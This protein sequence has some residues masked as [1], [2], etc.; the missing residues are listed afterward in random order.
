MVQFA[1]PGHLVGVVLFVTKG[2][3]AMVVLWGVIGAISEAASTPIIFRWDPAARTCKTC[4]TSMLMRAMRVCA[5]GA[6][7][8]SRSTRFRNAR[9]T[10]LGQVLGQEQRLSFWS[11]R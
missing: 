6:L 4:G 3:V 11:T 10:R 7:H 5:D 2:F 8:E 1:G 9:L